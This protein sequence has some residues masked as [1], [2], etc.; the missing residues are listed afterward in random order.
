MYN[1]TFIDTLFGEMSEDFEDWDSAINYWQ[2]YADTPTCICGRLKEIE[3]GEAI[4]SFN[5]QEVE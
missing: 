5:D 2:D 1:V 3:T 4:W